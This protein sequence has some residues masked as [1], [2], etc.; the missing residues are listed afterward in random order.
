MGASRAIALCHCFSG[1]LDFQVGRWDIAE[2]DL[3]EAVSLYRSI[4]AASGEALSLQRLGVLLTARGQ[5]AGGLEVL[6]AGL[7]VAERAIMR[8]HCLTRIQASLA[9]NRLAA[10][11]LEGAEA[12]I[13][14]GDLHAARHGHCVT[15]NALL[16]PEAVR[17]LAA[18]GSIGE[19]DVRA[20]SLERT[21]AEFE[22][23]AWNAMALGARARVTRAK[24]DRKGAADLLQRAHDHWLAVDANYE[25]ARCLAGLGEALADPVLIRAARDLYDRLGAAGI[26]D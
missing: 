22:S 10:G 9:R 8:S 5:V 1:A 21:A 15:C 24:G 7:V 26:E 6:E 11:D 20:A 4:Q 23:H 13:R 19:A 2:H 16:Q 12:A 3:R 25:A 14:V 18:R 17:V